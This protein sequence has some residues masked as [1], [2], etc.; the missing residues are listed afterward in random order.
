MVLVA[1]VDVLAGPDVGYLAL[2]SLGPAFA[3]VTGSVRRAVLVGAVAFVLC[4]NVAW[5]DTLLTTRRAVVALAAVVGA[6]AAALAAAVRRRHERELADVRSVA[7]AA[8]R[9]LLRPVP[10]TAGRMRVAV[11]YTSAAAEA[12]IGG[13]LYE[14][15]PAAA[16]GARVIVG[17][18]QGKGLD[19]VETAA[20]VLGA[21]R[22]AAPDE[23]YLDAVGRRLERALNRR[24]D[25]EEFVTAV[26]AEVD[27]D[28]TVTLLNYGHPA[29]LLIGADGT[30]RLAE[31]DVAAPP[32]GLASLGPAGPEAHTVDLRPG[33]QMLLY[34]DGVAEARN[35]RGEF[36][37]LVDRAFLLDHEDPERALEALRQDLV[38]HAG[39]PSNDDAAMLLLR[40]RDEPDGPSQ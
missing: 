25:G 13:D 16:G 28:H 39:G 30:V 20:L 6:T 34:T 32:L 36:Y 4:V 3:C 11:S 40:Y 9:V 2:F 27:A 26:L 12:R 1:S 17:D 37:P 19:A 8:Q 29:P 14:V 5:Y 21:F 33:D 7:E 31:P 22:E 35:S 18:V 15:V 23:Q 24:L 38:S 10:R